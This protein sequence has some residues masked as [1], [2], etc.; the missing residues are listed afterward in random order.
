MNVRTTKKPRARF[1]ISY[2]SRL[3]LQSYGEDNLYPQ[4]LQRITSASGTAVACLSRYQKF[5]EGSGFVEGGDVLVNHHANTAD[6]L[7]HDV[8]QDVTEFGGFALHVNYNVFGQITELQ[9]IPFENC[10]LSEPDDLGNVAHILV[11]PDWSGNKTRSGRR[12]QV[13]EKSV[14]RFPVFNA[15]PD[16]VIRQIAA[17]GG[18][19]NYRGQIAWFSMN[20]KWVYPIPIYDAAIT[21]IST[22][23]GLGNIK[24]RNARN[25]FLTACMLITKKGVP[26]IDPKT[27]AEIDASM[28]SD[29][30]LRQFQGDEN[31]SKMLV[32]ELEND[33][34]KPEVVSFPVANYDKDFSVTD[35]SVIERIY[36]QFHQELFHAI[37]I[38][39]LGFSGDVMRDAYDYYAGEVTNEQRFIARALKSV[40]KHTTAANFDWRIKP[41]Q[42]MSNV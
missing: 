31:T 35:A 4:N 12:L 24:Y 1:D 22:D 11:H 29:E 39:K 8:A 19:D 14:Q 27:G 26:K 16:V 21:E 32:V 36:A 7:L 33:E 34:D 25:N 42:Y 41:L 13:N 10:R 5:V 17:A 28:I 40:T 9:Y 30:D 37:R 2:I 18:I 38:G 20:G 6:D 15:N 23:E 3:D